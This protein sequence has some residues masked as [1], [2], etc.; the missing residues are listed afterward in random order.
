MRL[1][2][3][4]AWALVLVS[5]LL[6]TAIFP[7]AGPLPLWRAA[8]C[9]V[10][11]VPFLIALLQPSRSGAP[12]TLGGAALLGYVCGICWYIGTCYWIYQTMHIYGCL[13]GP[14]EGG[15]RGLFVL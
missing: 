11:L 13:A 8:L 2:P 12:L 9:W 6:Q 5:A 14:V 3:A 10:A 7:I 15:G 4:R 1:I